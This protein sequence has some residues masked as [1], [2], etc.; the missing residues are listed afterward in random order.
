MSAT[1]TILALPEAVKF[2]ARVGGSSA[3]D[4]CMDVLHIELDNCDM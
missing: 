3:M 1:C 4:Y 2:G